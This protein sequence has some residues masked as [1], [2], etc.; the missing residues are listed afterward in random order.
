MHANRLIPTYT[1]SSIHPS[2]HS[3]TRPVRAGDAAGEARGGPTGARVRTSS[4]SAHA[5]VRVCLTDCIVC[6]PSFTHLD[7][8]PRPPPHKQ[9][10]LDSLLLGLCTLPTPSTPSTPPTPTAEWTDLTLPVL[11]A[12]LLLAPPLGPGTVLALLERVDGAVAVRPFPTFLLLLAPPSST[13]QRTNEPRHPKTPHRRAARWR[14][15]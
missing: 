3:S 14:R 2:I 13:H 6:G 5:R 10:H 7:T 15:R 11:T 12:V 4:L 8:H 9:E 1:S